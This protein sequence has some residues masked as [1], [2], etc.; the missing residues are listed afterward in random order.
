MRHGICQLPNSQ[1]HPQYLLKRKLHLPVNPRA[2]CQGP[3]GHPSLVTW[4]NFLTST[5]RHC[6][7]GSATL[8][9]QF[10]CPCWEIQLLWC[11]QHMDVII[12]LP[13][14]LLTKDHFFSN[15][16]PNKHH[17]LLYRLVLYLY[18]NIWVTFSHKFRTPFFDAFLDS[19]LSYTW[20]EVK[21]YTSDLSRPYFQEG[22][23]TDLL[24]GNEISS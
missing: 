3:Q 14:I 2:P 5:E 4:P 21:W 8:S 23:H 12:G 22:L 17:V 13:E 10:S 9:A 7:T 11:V 16:N 15:L 1:I 24:T 20:Q 6:R 19:R 18:W